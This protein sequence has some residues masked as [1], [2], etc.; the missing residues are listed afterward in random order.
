VTEPYFTRSEKGCGLGLALV[1][2][3]AEGHGWTLG[4]QSTPGEGTAVS[5]CG[6]ESVS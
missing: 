2:Q 4:I 5:F 3:I 6:L 1:Q